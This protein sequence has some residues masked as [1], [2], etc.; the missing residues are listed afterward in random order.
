VVHPGTIMEVTALGRF[1]VSTLPDI[2][3]TLTLAAEDFEAKTQEIEIKRQVVKSVLE[4]PV[5]RGNWVSASGVITP[6]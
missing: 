2:K 1:D 5:Q 6:A 4:D 3:L